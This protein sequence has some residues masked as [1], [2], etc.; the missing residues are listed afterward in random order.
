MRANRRD[1]FDKRYDGVKSRA[2]ID[3]AG[4]STPERAVFWL[5]E[6][7]KKAHRGRYDT[8]TAARDKAAAEAKLPRTMAKRI[9]DRWQSMKDVSGDAV[10]KL[11]TAYDK[12]CEAN[13]Q[14]AAAYRDERLRIARTD[15]EEASEKPAPSR[16]GTNP[17]GNRKAA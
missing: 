5:N 16:V 17:A 13:E 3:T 12:M 1:V 7:T 8:W 9:W 4:M 10:L 6:L 2:L 15:H 11:M 14:A